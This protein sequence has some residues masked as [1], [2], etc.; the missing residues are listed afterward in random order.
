VT[1]NEMMRIFGPTKQKITGGWR[2][3]HYEELRNL[4]FL[5]TTIMVL[6]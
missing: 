6:K 3:L 4:F 2:K 5:P 1:E